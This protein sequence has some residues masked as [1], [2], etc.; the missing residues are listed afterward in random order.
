MDAIIIYILLFLSQRIESLSNEFENQSYSNDS[1]E[2]ATQ[3][4][5]TQ[6]QLDK[7]V[8]HKD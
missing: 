4:R 8:K 6:Q 1:V 7:L 2:S 3:I 5:F